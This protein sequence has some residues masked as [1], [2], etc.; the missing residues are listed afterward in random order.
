MGKYFKNIF[1][2]FG[3]L[4]FWNSLAFSQEIDSLKLD[5]LINV[6]TL[7]LNNER[8]VNAY[9]ELTNDYIQIADY[10]TALR[11]AKLGLELS[12]K[13]GYK[14]GELESASSAA[15][16]YLAYYLDYTESIKLYDRAYEIADDLDL[17]E[18][19][20]RIYRGYTAIFS[21]LEDYDQALSYNSLAIDLAN[22]IG[23]KQ[24]VSDL[25]SYGGNIYEA[26]GDTVK[27]MEM[28]EQ[29]VEIETKNNFKNT[30]K[31]SL[32]IVAHYYHLKGEIDKSLKQYRIALKRFERMKDLRWV[33]YTHSEMAKIYLSQENLERAEMHGL[34][35]FSIAQELD[36]MKEKMDNANILAKLYRQQKNDSL[37]N[38]YQTMH[39]S[40][41]ALTVTEIKSDVI[42]SENL[43]DV[44]PKPVKEKSNP[45]DTII[46][47]LVI[48]GL[49][50]VAVF[51]TGMKKPSKK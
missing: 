38:H 40:L 39:D 33:A 17:D 21:A 43:G 48:L 32:I 37:A 4:F 45:I 22:K 8:T 25:S 29:V 10:K 19:K 31:A 20:I 18:E 14:E 11:Y 28:Y 13:I 7:Q 35:G 1:L 23:D 44:E 46:N 2:A 49:V 42:I 50:G 16:I 12:E 6:L 9:T 51:I 27:A 3:F 5:T 47:L 34:K 41:L 15:H 24:S 26:T 36:L 30:S